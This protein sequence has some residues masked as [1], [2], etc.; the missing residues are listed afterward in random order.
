MTS[1]EESLIELKV[2]EKAPDFTV[3]LYPSGSLKLAELR[4]K[5]NLILAFYPKDSTPGCS[6]E[7]CAFSESLA[8]FESADTLVLGV[9]CDS[10]ESHERFSRKHNLKQA[11]V[12]DT[13]GELGRL[14][15]ALRE[16]HRS[17]NRKLFLIDKN[18][19]I[20]HI[21]NGMPDIKELLELLKLL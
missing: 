6:I 2:G 3:T 8:S 14:Y 7:M 4:G 17:A 20:R 13:S 18:G 15:G 5:K 11:L 10:M 19:T 21:H 9:S 1:Q 16:G 12:S